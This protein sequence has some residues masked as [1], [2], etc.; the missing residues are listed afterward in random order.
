MGGLIG[1][2][3]CSAVLQDLTAQRQVLAALTTWQVPGRVRAYTGLMPSAGGICP[4]AGLR[5]SASSGRCL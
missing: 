1:Y 2:A 4:A 3:R 5:L